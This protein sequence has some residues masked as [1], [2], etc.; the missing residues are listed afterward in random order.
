MAAVGG[1]DPRPSLWRVLCGDG[2]HAMDCGFPSCGGLVIREQHPDACPCWL[3]HSG[4]GGNRSVIGDLALP[5]H[6][7]QIDDPQPFG[8]GISDLLPTCAAPL[9]AGW[10]LLSLGT[11]T[12]AELAKC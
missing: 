5:G 12:Q 6:E 1:G 9:A 3:C 2:A 4:N 8:F 11:R 7:R 10:T